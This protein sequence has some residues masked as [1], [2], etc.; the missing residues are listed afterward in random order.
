MRGIQVGYLMLVI[1]GSNFLEAAIF[2]NLTY[3]LK[4]IFQLLYYVTAA[5][6]GLA[7]Y[8]M[9]ERAALRFAENRVLRAE[10]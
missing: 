8:I 10:V 6:G 4:V 2:E 1:G 5:A 7:V 3:T 9:L